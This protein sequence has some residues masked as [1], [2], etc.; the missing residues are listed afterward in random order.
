MMYLPRTWPVGIPLLA[1]ESF[2]SWFARI[3]WVHG[4]TPSELYRIAL[5]GGRIGGIDLDRHACDDPIFNLSRHAGIPAEILEA[6]TLRRWRGA[7]YDTDDGKTPITCFRLPAGP[8]PEA[9]SGSRSAHPA[10]RRTGSR[11]SGRDGASASTASVPGISVL[12]STVAQVAPVRGRAPHAPPQ[13]THRAEAR[14]TPPTWPT[15]LAP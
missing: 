4:A 11:T 7:V 6:A 5:P 10:W 13:R 12:W 2:S 1:A 15:V 8:M 3:A 9:R 14:A